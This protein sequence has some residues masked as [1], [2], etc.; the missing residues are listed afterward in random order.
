MYYLLAIL[1]LVIFI[2]FPLLVPQSFMRFLLFTGAISLS[3]IVGERTFLTSIGGISPTAF[4]LF[5]VMIAGIIILG[6]EK[7]AINLAI[8]IKFHL[9]FITYATLSLIWCEDVIYGL[10]NIAKLLAPPLLLLI[11]QIALPSEQEI[12][13]TE[14]WIFLGGIFIIILG[15]IA[16]ALGLKPSQYHSIPRFTIPHLNPSP[17]SFYMLMLTLFSIVS[18]YYDRKNIYLLLFF[19]FS[20]FCVLP[21]TRITIG[22]LLISL[23]VFLVLITRNK[24]IKTIMFLSPIFLIPFFIF[25]ST[26]ISILKE[27]MFLNPEIVSFS[28]IF[29]NPKLFLEQLNTSGRTTLWSFALEKFFQKNPLWGSGAGATQHFFYEKFG[30]GVVHSEYIRLLCELGIIGCTFF[31]I[32]FLLYL[33]DMYKIW[34]RAKEITT[35]KYALTAILCLTSYLIISITD[36]AID[37]VFH[38]SM[39]VFAFT[40]FA[41][42]CYEQENSILY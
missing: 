31:I 25:L 42:Q 24:I 28:T 3:F 15:I 39:Y 13:K 6:A 40:A 22:A 41:Y 35:K 2:L 16:D 36:N 18:F 1:L 29:Q 7:R 32:V 33:A 20:I 14:K 10:R 21:L 9:L 26:S 30:R 37:Y 17:F 27:R 4:K 38:L 8:N 34:Q 19:L 23:M 11:F 5:A 12:R